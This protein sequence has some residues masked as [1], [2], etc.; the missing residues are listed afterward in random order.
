MS[1]VVALAAGLATQAQ[2]TLSYQISN[3]GLETANV[4]FD[5]T[6][7]NGIL[8][9][10]IGVTSTGG[11]GGS[12]SFVSICTDFL[13]SLYLGNT[14]TYNS[15]V[16]ISSPGLTGI[17]PTWGADNAGKTSGTADTTSATYGLDNAAELFYHN[18]GVLTSGTTDQKAALQLAI[19]T[20]LYDTTSAGAVDVTGSRFSFNVASTAGGI[21]LNWLEGLVNPT[22]SSYVDSPVGLLVPS[23]AT[24]ANGSN[25][26]GEP[27]QEL[28]VVMPTPQALAPTPV[29]EASTVITGTLLL[30]SFGVCSLKSFGKS[31]S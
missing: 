11:S 18:I 4:T 19:W 8:A 22:S 3:A 5:G 9:G 31:R 6:S 20:A 15:P 10:G 1:G 23:P 28:L 7:Y 25:P 2:A 14:Y 24:A 17:A 13:G 21:A 30:L 27:P 26:D 29:P 16:S 12:S